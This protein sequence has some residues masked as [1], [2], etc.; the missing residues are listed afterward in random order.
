M[1]RKHFAPG[2]FVGASFFGAAC[3]SPSR[4]SEMQVLQ[5]M[6]TQSI[7]ASNLFSCLFE[8]DDSGSKPRQPNHCIYRSFS[9]LLAVTCT[10]SASVSPINSDK[11]FGHTQSS[12]YPRNERT[13]HH[14]HP[15]PELDRSNPYHF[16]N[17]HWQTTTCRLL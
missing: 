16:T 5:Q 11:P 9:T 2:P 12:Q 10:D 8:N 14:W 15:D 6:Y 3:V 7:R 4:R 17:L 1:H 13:R